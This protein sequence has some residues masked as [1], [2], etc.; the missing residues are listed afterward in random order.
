MSGSL[1]PFYMWAGGKTRLVKHYQEVW[2]NDKGLEYVEPFFGGG[3]VFCWRRNELGTLNAHL[4]DVNSEVMG[5]LEAVKTDPKAFIKVSKGL[6]SEMVKL[7]SK[8]ER[9]E[10]YYKQR[11]LY[12]SNPTPARLYVLMRTGFNG[13]WQTCKDS[14]GLFGTPAGL[15]N[16]STVEKVVDDANITEWSAALQ[17]A[18]LHAGSYESMEIPGKRSLIYLDPPYRGS[19]TTYGT[20]FSDEDQ[21]RLTK[22]YR[23]R[24]EEGHKVVLANRCVDDDEFFED[25]VGD[26]ATFHYFDVTYTAGRRKKVDDGYEAKAAREFI[27]VSK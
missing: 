12:W 9:K 18:S 1:S 11:T 27:A 20:G 14:N 26:I 23:E 8:E 17:G 15:L 7:T 10:W 4:G 19:F 6:A 3:A 22:W 21:V 2:P 5:V 13:V 24:V 16:Q 25:L